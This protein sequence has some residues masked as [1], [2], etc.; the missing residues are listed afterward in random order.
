[1]YPPRPNTHAA[2]VVDD[3][4]TL[5]QCANRYHAAH[6]MHEHG[7]SFR[8]IVRVL[9]PGAAVRRTIGLAQTDNLSNP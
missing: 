1:M 6:S 7:I 8:V 4:L 9:Q 5:L 3:G 2:G